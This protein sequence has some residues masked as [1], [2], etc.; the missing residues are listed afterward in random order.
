MLHLHVSMEPEN[1]LTASYE[2]LSAAIGPT[3]AKFYI[4]LIRIDELRKRHYILGSCWQYDISLTGLHK[5]HPESATAVY[6]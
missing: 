2:T 4:K 1:L 3:P 5:Q 6:K